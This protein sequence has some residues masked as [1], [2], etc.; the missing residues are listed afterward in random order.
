MHRT[1]KTPGKLDRKLHV[2]TSCFPPE[3]SDTEQ[4]VRVLKLF[5][6]EL[7]HEPENTKSQ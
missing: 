3:A 6:D 7:P 5:E 2:C 4:A 1:K